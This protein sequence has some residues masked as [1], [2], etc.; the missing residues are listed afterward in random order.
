MIR[1]PGLQSF[2]PWS[3]AAV[4]DA[5]PKNRE[6]T[7][8]AIRE[9]ILNLKWPASIGL[10]LA[11]A[12]LIGFL[13]SLWVMGPGPLNPRKI[14]WLTPDGATYHIAWELF[15]QDPE[16]HWPLTF[17][18]RIGYPEGDSISLFDPNS[19][20]VVLL[21]PFSRL[22]PEPFQYLGLEVVLICT[23]QFFFAAMLFRVLFGDKAFAVV[24]PALFFLIAPPLTWR[25][26][27]HYALSN[28]WLLL[29]S[30]LLFCVAQ[31][32]P[33]LHA[34]RFGGWS[35]ILIALAIPINAYLALQ[36][37]F[38][39]GAALVSL[40]W[41]RRMTIMRALGIVALVGLTGYIVA[42]AFGLIM[43]GGQGYGAG[44]YRAYS[45]N[46]L[47]FFDPQEHGSL[48]LPKMPLAVP[49]QYEG[50]N[51]LGL[52]IIL[53]GVVSLPLLIRRRHKFP[54]LQHR[55]LIPLLSS[56][57]I[58]TL[59]ALST[60]ITFGSSVLVDL[61]P[62][63]GL[64][65]LLSTL[66]SSGRL[67]W[68]PYYILL[69]G[70]LAATIVS[71][72]RSWAVALM[73]AAL[74]LQLADTSGL[75]HWV[76]S[77]VNTAHPSP[78]RSPVWSKLGGLYQNLIIVPP[79]QCGVESPGAASG[80]RIFGFLAA[81][82]HMRINSYYAARYTEA[83]QAQCGS[84]ISALFHQ[85]LSSDSAYV[86]TLM[87]AQ[88]IAKGPTGPGKCHN[89]DQFILCS[90]KNDFGLGP[91][92]NP[93]ELV[94]NPL[95]NPGFEE[96]DLSAWPTFQNV[97]AAVS[98]VRAHSGHY[99][100]AQANG[101]GSVYQDVFGLEPGQ[102]Y[103]VTAWV[104]GTPGTT[105]AAQIAV[106]DSGANVAINSSTLVPSTNWQLMTDSVTVRAPGTLRI[107]LFRN[108][109]TGTI[110]WDDVRIYRER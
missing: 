9:R 12:A 32:E 110:F 37:L 13:Y 79:W 1:V 107:H 53:L 75:R 72:R 5:A 25:F 91:D 16:L 20:L 30:L 100:L 90:P 105:A 71:F 58:L 36:V 103:T 7:R 94:Q 22:L 87:M 97:T 102:K 14:D 60:R 44:G 63:E 65:P 38:V 10:N 108:Q 68:V 109:G 95:G 59:L 21:K 86:V 78:L 31:R 93:G 39:I 8:I 46:L 47:A 50:Y 56:C 55:I 15:R 62:H 88:Q 54:I 6:Q 74:V 66:R 73:S 70:I 19:L 29:A 48:L 24:L 26:I 35:V 41:R 67:V 57:L 101:T 104:S 4:N 106:Y 34:V 11:F 96:R 84:D 99:S 81:A 98:A 43:Q 82:Q 61:D 51:Y 89:L 83:R 3:A 69:G 77:E 17:T 85:P 49:E 80:Y 64:T 27:G 33:P 45:L 40:V 2:W 52:G 28:H 18:D 76:H 92:V 23:L 42:S